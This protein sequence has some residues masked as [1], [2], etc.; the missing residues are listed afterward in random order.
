M[1]AD[2]VKLAHQLILVTNVFL[3]LIDKHKKKTYACHSTS[4]AISEAVKR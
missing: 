3:F 2:Q 4:R 1:N